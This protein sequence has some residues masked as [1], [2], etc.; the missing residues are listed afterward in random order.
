MDCVTACWHKLI[1]EEK[2][3][4]ITELSGLSTG[5]KKI[6]IAIANGRNTG[7]TG[8]QFLANIDMTGSSVSEALKVLEQKDYI[9]RLANPPFRLVD[10]LMK[11]ALITYFDQ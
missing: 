2:L 9:E 10:P 5:Q 1:Q 7:L 6:L 11:S 8:K 3:E 4:M